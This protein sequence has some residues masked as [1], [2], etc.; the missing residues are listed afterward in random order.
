M[1][2]SC[3]RHGQLRQKWLKLIKLRKK[4]S[5]NR[6]NFLEVLQHTRLLGFWT[7][8]MMRVQ[9]VTV[10]Q[11]MVW[12]WMRQKLFLAK[13]VPRAQILMMIRLL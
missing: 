4:N 11:V 5:L 10:K 1:L 7:I 8:Q 6:E 3:I 13:R 9:P 2:F 12:Y